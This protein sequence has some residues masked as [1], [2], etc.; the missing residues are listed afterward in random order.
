MLELST[1]SSTC[2]RIGEGVGGA[3]RAAASAGDSIREP[4]TQAPTAITAAHATAAAK[5]VVRFPAMI[6]APRHSNLVHAH[7]PPV[8][9]SDQ[10]CRADSSAPALMCGVYASRIVSLGRARKHLALDLL[11][12]GLEYVVCHLEAFHADPAFVSWN[13]LSAA[14]CSGVIFSTGMVPPV[15]IR[16]ADCGCRVR[17]HPG[18]CSRTRPRASQPNILQCGFHP[19]I[20]VDQGTLRVVISGFSS[21]GLNTS[22]TALRVQPPVSGSSPSR[23]RP[24]TSRPCSRRRA[25]GCRRPDRQGQAS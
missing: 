2:T 19:R 6:S 9:D 1:R 22:D 24:R 25:R 16:R 23:A 7:C 21:S 15:I 13:F 8:R 20:F 17:H 14:C 3:V 5:A 4:A 12:N 11:L 10:G 18:D